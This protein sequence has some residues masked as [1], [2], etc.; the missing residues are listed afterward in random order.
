MTGATS[1]IGK[2]L[3]RILYSKNAKV[4][5]A[6]RRDGENAL[7]TIKAS[8]PRSA[9]SLTFL[10]VDLSD[11]ASVKTA[12]DKFLAA[13]SKLHVLFN[14]AGIM[15]GDDGENISRTAQGYEVQLG[16]NCLGP[17][18]LTK[19][20]LPTLRATAASRDD[21]LVTNEVR[22]VFVS[23]FA[24]EMHHEKCVG[25]DMADLDYRQRPRASIQRYG[26]S[27]VGAWCYGVELSRRFR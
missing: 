5:A 10:P 24:A 2:E 12:A 21:G 27:K 7:E 14:N 9:G 18:L 4:Y 3:A 1:G 17:F 22:V 11:L 16:V 13:E 19:L 8:E 6:A 26:V 23:S 25:I 20:L 15:S